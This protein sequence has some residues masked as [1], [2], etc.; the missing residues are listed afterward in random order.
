[1]GLR[2]RRKFADYQGA[3]RLLVEEITTHRPA[4]LFEIRVQVYRDKR[5]IDTPLGVADIDDESNEGLTP[6]EIGN[7]VWK[8]VTDDARKTGQ[9]KYRPVYGVRTDG[10]GAAWHNGSMLV[11][12]FDDEGT[13]LATE[14]TGGDSV[15]MV[16]LAKEIAK[17]SHEKHM[18]SLSFLLPIVRDLSAQR[19]EHD[20]KIEE[21]HARQ[22][23]DEQ[24][25]ETRRKWAD[26]AKGGIEKFM[27]PFGINMSETVEDYIREA[28]GIGKRPM[29][30]RWHKLMTELPEETVSKLR[31]H[32]GED[33]MSM[34]EALTAATSDD[35]F[36]A[37]AQSFTVRVGNLPNNEAIVAG[38]FLILGPA[39]GSR[40]SSLLKEAT[41][42]T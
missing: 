1:M 17:E 21:I 29:H 30:E 3:P 4:G 11:V 22:A 6:E 42:Q 34:I 40:F 27:E 31:E 13:P 14:S 36:C 15:D 2:L 18:E 25:H 16:R 32:L 10:T 37:L 23:E 20:V 7:A 28:T 39:R 41:G 26:V 12:S 5:Y 24:V 8:L 33:L 19:G 9:T 38:T 35:E